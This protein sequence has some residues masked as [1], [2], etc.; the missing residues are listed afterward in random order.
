MKKITVKIPDIL[1]SEEAG[2]FSP[3][4]FCFEDFQ[5]AI[6]H[7]YAGSDADFETQAEN[8]FERCA[9]AL[10]DAHKAG[11]SIKLPLEFVGSVN[12]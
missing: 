9:M 2:K 11:V 12:L 3:P 4:A 8:F 10:M 5:N 1:S 6:K 7:Y